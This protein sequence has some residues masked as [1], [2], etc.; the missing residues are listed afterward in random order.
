MSKRTLLSFE[1]FEK[2]QDDG[3]KHELIQASMSLCLRRR[4]AKAASAK[5]F[6]TRYS[7]MCGID[8]SAKSTFR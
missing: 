1:T 6:M 4:L 7:P 8:I 2:Y 3:I 5:I